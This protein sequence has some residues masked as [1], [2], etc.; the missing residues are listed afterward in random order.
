M[1]ATR[2]FLGL[3]VAGCAAKK[4]HRLSGCWLP[5]AISLLMISCLPE[6]RSSSSIGRGNNKNITTASDTKVLRLKENNNNKNWKRCLLP[7]PPASSSSSSTHNK[8]TP[9]DDFCFRFYSFC[10]CDSIMSGE[11]VLLLLFDVL[12][13]V[14]SVLAGAS[15]AVL[16]AVILALRQGRESINYIDLSFQF[17]GPIQ[18]VLGFQGF[19]SNLTLFSTPPPHGMLV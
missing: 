17:L 7:T 13:V 9:R 18:F 16:K 15:A 8:H 10:S 11:L 1:D 5:N 4:Q 19:L 6:C 2:S 14:S 12:A 3:I